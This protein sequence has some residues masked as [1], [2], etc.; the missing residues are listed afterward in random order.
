ME[1][2][3]AYTKDIQ[4]TDKVL[5]R[6]EPIP[7]GLFH[8]V[9]EV[10]VRHVDGSYLCMKRCET[11]NVYP[12]YYE[13]TAGGSA[14]W[15]E[16]PLSCVKREL[17]EETGIKC[18]D[19]E[20]VSTH[21]CESVATIYYCFACQV[22]ADKNSIVLQEGETDAYKWMSFDEFAKFLNS[23]RVIDTQKQRFFEY[24]KK[25]GLVK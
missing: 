24:Y 13:A 16:D 11:K 10:L 20:Q 12:G 2:W 23:D 5:I 17:F 18:S 6:G 22:D 15:G 1:K 25:M 3:N 21:V 14:L 8:L 19:F 4:L 9:C 7:K